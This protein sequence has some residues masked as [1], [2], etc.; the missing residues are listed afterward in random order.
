MPE[1]STSTPPRPELLRAGDP[2]FVEAYGAAWSYPD[3]LPKFF[4][5]DGTYT[6]RS[7]QVTVSGGDA[8]AR[9]MRVYHRASPDCV[10][11]FTDVIE[12]PGGFVAE[13]IWEG[14]STGPLWLLGVDSP[15]DGSHYRI[16]GVTLVRADE[17][18]RVASHVDY[19]DAEAMLRTWRGEGVDAPRFGG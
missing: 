1:T 4:A 11:T 12:H 8:L 19:W 6:D 7:S 10:V 3:L 15:Q 9:F 16:E 13:W 17:D 2:G 18:G 5:P 14:T